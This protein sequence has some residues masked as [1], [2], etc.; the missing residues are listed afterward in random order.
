[1]KTCL[2]LSRL[3][4]DPNDWMHRPIWVLREWLDAN[5]ELYE[6]EQRIEVTN[7]EQV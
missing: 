3:G 4:G 5:R 6:E 1:M 7:H 2:K